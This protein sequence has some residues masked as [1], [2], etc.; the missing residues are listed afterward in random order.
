MSFK[1]IYLNMINP[2]EPNTS[3]QI[4]LKYDTDENG[5]MSISIET[6][7]FEDNP[8][9]VAGFLSATIACFADPD[10]FDK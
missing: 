4:V 9:A 3:R 7:G 5:E 1:P 2:S 10:I 8:E 6:E